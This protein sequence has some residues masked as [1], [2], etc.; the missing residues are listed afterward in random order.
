MAA[1]DLIS[2]VRTFQDRTYNIA[3]VDDDKA[4]FILISRLLDY[5]DRGK[6]KLTHITSFDEAVK[7]LE[8][9]TY[10]VALID[11]FLG[12]KLGLDLIRRLG[13]RIAPCALIMLTGGVSNGLDLAALEA[14]VADYIDKNDLSA[15]MLAR[16]VIYAHARF[17]IERQFRKSQAKLRRARDE[18][19]AYSATIWMGPARQS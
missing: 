10:D 9:E 14:G 12:G 4:D 7:R 13:G 17:D 8:S 1:S 5:S 6:F 18:A 19:A 15:Q 11:Q 3:V 16:S 2:S